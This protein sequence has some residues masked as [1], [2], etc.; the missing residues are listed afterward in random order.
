M[1]LLSKDVVKEALM[2]ALGVETIDDSRRLGAA[3]IAVLYALARVNGRAVLE[4]NWSPLSIA[5]LRG[6]GG[7]VVEVFCDVDPAV[8][9]QRYIGRAIDR[10]PGHFDRDRAEDRSPWFGKAAQ[11]VDG[12]WPV[13]RV[14]TTGPV[15]VDTLVLE[16][17]AALGRH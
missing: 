8:S 6:L 3:A 17:R 2:D 15:D 1:P 5:E 14:D 9:H 10:H 16:V 4:S 13:L 12:G 7:H 11:P